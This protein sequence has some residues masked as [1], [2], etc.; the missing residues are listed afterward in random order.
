MFGNAQVTFFFSGG[1]AMGVTLC[2][3]R[4][5]RHGSEFDPAQSRVVFVVEIFGSQVQF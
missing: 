4:E 5:L 2:S 1:T 3:L